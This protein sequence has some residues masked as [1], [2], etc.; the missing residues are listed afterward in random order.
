M[1]SEPWA[2]FEEQARR[3]SEALERRILLV[4]PKLKTQTSLFAV[5][6]AEPTQGRLPGL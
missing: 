2:A 3:G 6:P 4:K 5:E 1:P